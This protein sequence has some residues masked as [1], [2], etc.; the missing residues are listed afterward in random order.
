MLLCVWSIVSAQV[1]NVPIQNQVYEFLNRMGVRGILPLYSN[2]M[3]PISRRE[4]ADP[5]VE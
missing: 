5:P 1:E 2:T 4:V 3:V